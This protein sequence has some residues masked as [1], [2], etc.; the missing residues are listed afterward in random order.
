[1][2]S[3]GL[4]IILLT[5]HSHQGQALKVTVAVLETGPFGILIKDKNSG[6]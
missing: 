5:G 3:K 4:V 6:N 1:M 2:T